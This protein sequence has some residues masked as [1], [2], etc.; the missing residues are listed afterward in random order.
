M[1]G[2]VCAEVLRWAYRNWKKTEVWL[3]HSTCVRMG[4]AEPGQV[5]GA[6]ELPRPVR[7][8]SERAGECRRELVPKIHRQQQAKTGIEKRIPRTEQDA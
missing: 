5:G 7:T 1:K 2:P 6:F 3:E 4:T 8:R